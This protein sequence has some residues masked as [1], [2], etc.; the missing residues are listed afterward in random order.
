MQTLQ[1]GSLNPDP[2]ILKRQLIVLHGHFSSVS[3][4]TVECKFDSIKLF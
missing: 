1:T 4:V 3:S 2:T